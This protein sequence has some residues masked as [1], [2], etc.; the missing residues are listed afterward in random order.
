[1]GADRY[2]SVEHCR[3]EPSGVEPELYWS[4]QRCRWEPTG[5]AADALPTPWSMFRPAQ[6]APD[7]PEQRQPDPAHVEA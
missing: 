3:W 5:P 7:L 6:P 4:V 2:W 1:M